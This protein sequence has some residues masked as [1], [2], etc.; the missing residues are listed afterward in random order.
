[1]MSAAAAVCAI[2]LSGI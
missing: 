1:M 2:E